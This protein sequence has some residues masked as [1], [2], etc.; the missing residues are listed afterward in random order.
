M[1]HNAMKKTTKKPMAVEQAADSIY[2][3]LIKEFD[4]LDPKNLPPDKD[5]NN[6]KK[7]KEGAVLMAAMMMQPD[8]SPNSPMADMLSCL[9]HYCD[10][11][12][13]S[14][15]QELD[16]ARFMYVTDTSP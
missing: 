16:N 4:G 12:G 1:K 5:G 9:M 15:N 6:L 2:E 11:A 8:V 13:L 3:R 14:W 10:R 7:A